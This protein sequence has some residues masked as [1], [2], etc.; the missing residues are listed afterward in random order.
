[1]DS[2]VLIELWERFRGY[3]K[4]I[5]TQA[6][7]KTARAGQVVVAEYHSKYGTDEVYSDDTSDFIAWKDT[8]G[9]EHTGASR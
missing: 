2:I 6:T 1:V 4:W 9:K 3:D 5:E 7:I 8:E